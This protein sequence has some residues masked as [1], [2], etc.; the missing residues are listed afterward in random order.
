MSLLAI[1]STMGDPRPP[2]VV[3]S[4]VG[5]LSV[6]TVEVVDGVALG[7]S[8]AVAVATTYMEQ[9]SAVTLTSEG[10]VGM[11]TETILI[12]AE[13]AATIVEPE[14]ER[15]PGVITVGVAAGYPD[16]AT[17][18]YI[19]GVLVHT[20]ESDSEGNLLSV[21]I[22]IPDTYA[23]GTY[24]LTVTQ[25]GAIASAPVEFT[26]L[27]DPVPDEVGPGE[28]VP[29]AVPQVVARWEFQDP[30]TGGLG[31]YVFPN[32]PSSWVTPYYERT[33]TAHHTV[34][35]DGQYHLIEGQERVIEW[36]FSGVC[37]TQA[38]YEALV[39]F[40]G[41][42]RRFYVVDHRGRAWVSTF[43]NVDTRPRLRSNVNNVLTDWLM[44]YTVE[45]TSYWQTP[46]EEEA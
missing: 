32:N 44:D 9:S 16:T 10:S 37:T 25:A 30:I 23:A 4:S 39:A 43:T 11:S 27:E 22:V 12:P 40:G 17:E 38:M 20:Q 28:D 14:L 26:I 21:P 34:A 3:L 5:A 46:A 15:A 35:R 8:G 31:T 36:S 6:T 1:L 41:L 24:A 33:L 7:G 2:R 13:L 19:N 18:F 45:V 42:Q 29:P